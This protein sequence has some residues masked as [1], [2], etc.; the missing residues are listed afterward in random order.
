MISSILAVTIN[1]DPQFTVTV[2]KHYFKTKSLNVSYQ[3]L[4]V[5]LYL[6]QLSLLMEDTVVDYQEKMC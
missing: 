3:S 2:T 5:L 6:W 1:Y 4:L